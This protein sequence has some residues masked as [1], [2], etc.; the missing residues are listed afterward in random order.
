MSGRIVGGTSAVPHSMPWQ[1]FIR[2]LKQYRLWQLFTPPSPP[3]G[4][5]DVT[6]EVQ[7][8]A[9]APLLCIAHLTFSRMELF[10]ATVKEDGRV[11]QS[12]LRNRNLTCKFRVEPYYVFGAFLELTIPLKCA[13]KKHKLILLDFWHRHCWFNSVFAPGSTAK[14]IFYFYLSTLTP[15]RLR[16][17]DS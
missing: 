16:S 4:C 9:G 8:P 7:L 2:I 14:V 3:P 17:S 5:G 15:I 6:T 1:I 11:A 10:Q 13:P 12:F